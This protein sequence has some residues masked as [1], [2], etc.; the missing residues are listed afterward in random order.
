MW[1][2]AFAALIFFRVFRV[3]RGQTIVLF[4]SCE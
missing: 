2:L 1:H 3:F 4:L